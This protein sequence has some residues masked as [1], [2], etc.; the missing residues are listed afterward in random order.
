MPGKPSKSARKRDQLAL[1]ALGERLIELPAEQ[2]RHIPLDEDLLDAVVTAAG[3][4]AR[5][6]LRRQRQLIGKL[7][8]QVDPEPIQ[9]ALDSVTRTERNAKSL[10]RHAERWRDRI[11]DGGIAELEEFF[12]LTGRDNEQLRRQVAEL[13][14]CRSDEERRIVRR[15]IFRAVHL[16]L[17]AKMQDAAP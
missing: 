1:Q 13:A 5:G 3:M 9:A 10:F 14:R 15:G 17:D 8:R 16:A 6:A 2:L 12:A 11:A 7:M 4:T